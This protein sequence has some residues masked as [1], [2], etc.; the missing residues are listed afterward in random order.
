MFNL[1]PTGIIVAAI[2]PA[3]LLL[4]VAV[5]AD[6]RPEPPLA[7]WTAFILG[8]VS[9]FVLRSVR[10]W[11]PLPIAATHDPWLANIEYA[12]LAVGL[13]EETIKIGLLC[14][15]A[16]L[17]KAFNEPMD[18]VVYGAA[19]G[20][21]F[22]AQ[23]NVGYLATF[24]DWETLAIVRGV[25]TV[26]FHAAL[27]IIAGAYIA[28]A[29]FGGALGAHQHGYWPRARLLLLAWIIPVLLHACF[30]FPLL[31]LRKQLAD[32]AL[33]HGLLQA[34]GLVIGFG[35]I[36]IAVRLAWRVAG[37]QRAWFRTSR[38]PAA[39]WRAMWVLLVIGAGVGFVGTALIASG[40]HQW[41]V[42]ASFPTLNFGIGGALLLFALLI[43][44][45]GSK[46]LSVAAAMQSRTIKT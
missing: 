6:R 33:T 16:W 44:A 34:A 39:A 26:P 46:H 14:A 45:R 19:I 25:L 1:V 37:H 27:G 2:A 31:A 17:S 30:D 23:E 5:A 22:A 12:L 20:L 32:D 21:G 3:L 28:S 41:R 13:P 43:Y 18:G 11:T 9:I 10:T 36:S 38:A 35:A 4:W 42:G 40:A 7:V 24:Q 29:R 8:I 15:F